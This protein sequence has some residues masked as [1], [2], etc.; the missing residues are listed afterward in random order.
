MKNIK[1]LLMAGALPVI[2]TAY[3]IWTA[4]FQINFDRVP[5]ERNEEYFIAKHVPLI[6]VLYY[7]IISAW[8][9]I[10]IAM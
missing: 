9:C 8:V 10:K 7:A 6:I 1:L 2:L 4:W 5:N 3:I